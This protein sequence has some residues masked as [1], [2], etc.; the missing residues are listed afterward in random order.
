MKAAGFEPDPW[1]EQLLQSDAQRALLLCARQVGKSTATSIL[2]LKTALTQPGST[3]V[4]VA[5]VEEQSKELLRKV[6]SSYNN[7]GRPIRVVREAITF[8][9]LA[10]GSRV[11][12]LP[13]KESRVRSYTSDLLIID[14]AARVRDD[15]FS[16]A[17]PTMAVSKGR[18]IALSTAFSKS[19]WFYREWTEGEEY[20]RLSITAHDC[21]RIPPE[22]L[23]QEERKLGSRWFSMEYLNIFGDDVSALFTTEEIAAALSDHSVKP[24]FPT[25]RLL[26]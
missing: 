20:L 10:N 2:A 1:Q 22:F 17:S 3:T 19:G 8:F 15:V 6:M 14:E 25:Q 5:P 9:E 26:V 21:P 11:L 4:I 13:G 23:R 24:L 18:F 16:G 12:A 7:I